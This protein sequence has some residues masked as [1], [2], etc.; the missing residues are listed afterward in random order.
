MTL[1][2]VND[3]IERHGYDRIVSA[4]H[5]SRAQSNWDADKALPSDFEIPVIDGPSHYDSEARLGPLICREDEVGA[6]LDNLRKLRVRCKGGKV[7][8]T[9]FPAELEIGFNRTLRLPEDGRV[10]DQAVRLGSIPINN[11]AGIAKKLEGSRNQSMMDMARKGGVF[12]PL[13]QREAMFL[14][15][16]A[17]QDAFAVRVFVGGVN[18]VSGLPWNSPSPQQVAT[19]DYLSVPPQQFLDGISVG[20]DIVKQFIAMPMGSGYSVEKQ[21]TGKETVGGMQLEIVPGNRWVLQVPASPDQ[22]QDYPYTPDY[23]DTPRMAGVNLMVLAKDPLLKQTPELSA[24]TAAEDEL[25]AKENRPVYMHHLYKSQTVR[26]LEHYG[27]FSDPDPFCA[28]VTVQMAA[29]YMLDLTLSYWDPKDGMYR[30]QPVIWA[31]WWTLEQCFSE[32]RQAKFTVNGKSIDELELYHGA[33]MLPRKGTLGE[34][35]IRDGDTVT[36]QTPAPAQGYQQGLS[37]HAGHHNANW[38]PDQDAT[39]PYKPQDHQQAPFSVIPVPQSTSPYRPDY[40]QQTPYPGQDYM[41][42]EMPTQHQGVQSQD[43]TVSPPQSYSPYQQSSPYSPSQQSYASPQQSYSSPQQSYSSPGQ[44]YSSPQQSYASPQQTYGQ[45]APVRPSY[46]QSSAPSSTP[47]RMSGSAPPAVSAAPMPMPA[48]GP[49]APA[50]AAP[51]LAYVSPQSPAP[52][53]MA[54]PSSP[55][56]ASPSSTAPTSYLP[57]SPAPPSSV[58]GPSGYGSPPPRMAAPPSTAPAPSPR[59]EQQE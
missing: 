43:W 31:P 57:Q 18:A 16:K 25:W 21:V 47:P 42:H 12:F 33:Q 4:K 41:A 3:L 22:P 44:S 51:A 59:S 28:G 7:V 58:Q 1:Q 9:S 54:S 50:S 6:F 46:P 23:H 19:Q 53:S 29:V 11:I 39:S 52:P 45:A 5:G 48:P 55:S 35:G 34:Q 10:H 14:S 20:R 40:H 2:Q 24:D 17:R 13:Y 30:V 15:F 38:F 26:L 27:Q 36:I 32:R 56:A 8:V 49:A 37:Y